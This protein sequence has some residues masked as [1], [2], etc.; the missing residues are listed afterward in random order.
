MSDD[1]TITE[2]LASMGI[3]HARDEHSSKDNCH[4]L[5]V[6]GGKLGRY[7]AHAAVELIAVAM[8]AA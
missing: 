6:E 7:D 4:T 8:A 1:R 5:T 2:I 3:S